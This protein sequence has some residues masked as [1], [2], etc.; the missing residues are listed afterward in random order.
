MALELFKRFVMK[1]LDDEGL[2]QNIRSAKRKV[3][4]RKS[5]VWD[6]LAEVF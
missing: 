5:V 1:K 6:L 3:E 2:A 4:R